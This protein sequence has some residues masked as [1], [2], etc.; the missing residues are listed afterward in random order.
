MP[1]AHT[2]AASRVLIT[3][4][5]GGIGRCLHRALTGRYARLRLADRAPVEAMG[6]NEETLLGDLADPALAAEAVR[7]IDCVVHFA[8]VPREA[9]WDAI[10]PNNIVATVALFEAARAAGVRRIVFASSNH[11]IGFNRADAYVG[12]DEPVRPDSRYGV[13]KVF[14]E[15]LARLF[16]DKY[17]MSVA[18][19]R[20]GS[21]RE[22]PEDARQLATW[23]SPRDMAELVRCAI[24]APD[25]GFAVVYGISANTRARWTSPDAARIGYVPRDDAEQY[26]AEIAHIVPPP[27]DPAARFHGGAFCGLEHVDPPEGGASR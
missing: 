20:I 21:F 8:G 24:E 10:L 25:Y 17:A 11:A 12:I 18:C 16:V 9:P 23:I 22:R 26:A 2:V 13:S 14:G 4:A 3:G 5:A 1:K 27:Q 19:L 15:A 7:D 6:A